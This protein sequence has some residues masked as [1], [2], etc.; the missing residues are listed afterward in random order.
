M[1][2]RVLMVLSIVTASLSLMCLCI[3]VGAI[4]IFAIWSIVLNVPLEIGSLIVPAIVFAAI[5]GILLNLI[6][7]IFTKKAKA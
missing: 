5:V 3:V 7:V 4:V 6:F 2:N 1:M